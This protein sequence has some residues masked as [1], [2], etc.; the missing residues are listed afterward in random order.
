MLP[1]K[2]MNHAQPCL[3]YCRIL[4]AERDRLEVSASFGSVTARCA[5]SCLLEPSPGDLTLV[6]LDISGQAWILAVLERA[7]H[8]TANLSVEGDARFSARGGSLTVACDH[9]LRFTCPGELSA[10]AQA[11]VVHASRGT[12]VLGAFSLLGS[13]LKTQV[14]RMQT[15]ARHVELTCTELTQRLVRGSRF[16]QEH[17]EEQVGSKR[18][19]AEDS[20]SLHAKNHSIM[21]EE[22]VVIN[23]DQINMG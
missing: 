23:A 7:G 2:A 9:D 14:R 17:D 18:V 11:L 15:V 5:A 4:S 22:Q 1:A 12:A 19:L 16:V 13:T 21:A 20:L 10:G 8:E 3:E 6:S